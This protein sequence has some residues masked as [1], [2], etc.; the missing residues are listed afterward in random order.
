MKCNLSK[1]KFDDPQNKKEE[2]NNG[3]RLSPHKSPFRVL[4]EGASE[5]FELP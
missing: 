3:V 1:H 4:P 2:E 5:M